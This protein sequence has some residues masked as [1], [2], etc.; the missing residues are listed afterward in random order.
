ATPQNQ[1]KLDELVGYAIRYYH[2]FVLPAKTFRAPS[3]TERA[4]FADLDRRLAA[5]PA[6]AEAE[7]IQ[8]EVYAVG[9]AHDFEPLRDWFT[10]IYQVLLGQ[11]QGPRFG[12]FVALYGVAETRALIEKALAGELVN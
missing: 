6:G 1:P 12:S 4:A 7:T 11:D 8:N 3:E 2:D 10:A 5:L 9:K